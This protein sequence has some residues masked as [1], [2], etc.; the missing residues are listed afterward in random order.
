[1]GLII[2]KLSLKEEEGMA[3]NG[4]MWNR[5]EEKY[6]VVVNKAIK[7]R[8]VVDELRRCF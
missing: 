7:C 6:R 1:M 3:C 4:F 5:I 2:L 8:G